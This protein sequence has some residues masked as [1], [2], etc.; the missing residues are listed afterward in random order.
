VTRR[1]LVVAW[2][3]VG[4]ALWNGVFDLYVSRGVREYL[5]MQAE[6]QASLGPEPIMADVLGR[7]RRDGLVA[8]TLWA[9][10]VAGLGLATV[11]LGARG[12][13][14]GPRAGAGMTKDRHA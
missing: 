2:I 9:G 13:L 8:A 4:A 6:F 11:R 10:L 7:H 3:V 14:I 1:T 12:R 5:E